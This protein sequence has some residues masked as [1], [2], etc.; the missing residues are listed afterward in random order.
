MTC[1]EREKLKQECT[2][3]ESQLAWALDELER[4]VGVSLREEYER[5]KSAVADAQLTAELAR[6]AFKQHLSE[7]GC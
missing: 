3:A 6:I 4:G 7:H 2:E 5:L 1:A